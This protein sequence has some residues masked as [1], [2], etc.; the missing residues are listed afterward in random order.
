[1]EAAPLVTLIAVGLAIAVI[2]AFLLTVIYQLAQVFSRL[3]EILGAVGDVVEKTEVLDPVISEIKNDLAA[4]EGAISD[5]V[6]R[7][8]TRKGD[9]DAGHDGR[10]P[11]AVGT[12]SDAAPWGSAHHRS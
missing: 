11:T 1:M 4:G 5:A 10:E 12:S 8:K 3:N 9:P 2:A 7:L 6:E